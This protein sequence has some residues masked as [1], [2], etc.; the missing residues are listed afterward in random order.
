MSTAQTVPHDAQGTARS[1]RLPTRDRDSAN[2]GNKPPVWPLESSQNASAPLAARCGA[3]NG[4]CCKELKGDDERT[5]IDP[6]VV[7][8]I[9]IG[10]SDGLTVPFAL[11]AG[12]SSLGE[13]KLVVLG[14]VAEL[15]A[16]AISMGIGGFLASQAE[17]DHYY[18]QRTQTSARVLRSCDGEMQREVHA[19]LGPVGIDETL[20]TKI[21]LK[22]REV[23]LDARGVRPGTRVSSIPDTE[24][25]ELRWSADVGL[26]AFLLKFGEGLEEVPTRRLY[27]SAFTIGM[28]YLLGGLIPLLPYFFTPKA[29]VGLLY[30]CLLTAFVLL[31]FGAVKTHVTGGTGGFKGYAWGA[32]STLAVGGCAAGAAWGVVKALEG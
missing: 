28:G 10:L 9:V 3:N 11:T 29:S 4:V 26:T 18:Y 13:S 14:G 19:V 5:L 27:T 17:R 12:L 30:S 25:G 24:A 20:S 8:D 16:G 21:A 6:D 2:L 23:E 1:V 22:L 15:I 7:R 31:I 32:V